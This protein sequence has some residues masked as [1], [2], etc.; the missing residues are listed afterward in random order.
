MNSVL[1]E[2]ESDYEKI[3]VLMNKIHLKV[4]KIY[5]KEKYFYTRL[6]YIWYSFHFFPCQCVN[7]MWILQLKYFNF[8][9]FLMYW[10][11]KF[12]WY[13]KRYWERCLKR[14]WLDCVSQGK[15]AYLF[16]FL[17]LEGCIE[18]QFTLILIDF[19]P[20]FNKRSQLLLELK[21]WR[22]FQQRILELGHENQSQM[23]YLQKREGGREW[24]FRVYLFFI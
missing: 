19:F 24:K 8:N 20:S 14:T 12:R 23:Y 4:L 2:R 10:P 11:R 22:S 13:W 17:M 16:Q 6:Y 15:K 3:H 1:M 9:N 18:D 7:I 5:K 21:D